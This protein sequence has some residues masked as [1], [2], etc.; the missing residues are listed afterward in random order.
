[1]NRRIRLHSAAQQ[2]LEDAASFYDLEEPGLGSSFLDDFER[3]GEQIRLL[4]ESSPRI[5][6]HA[7]K[8]LMARIP[9]AVVYSLLDDEVFVLAEVSGL[10]ES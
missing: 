2:E 4:P 7:R 9:Y 10:S 3:A 1:M 8:K 6:K 5:G